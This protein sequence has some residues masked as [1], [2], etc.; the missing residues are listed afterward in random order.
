MMHEILHGLGATHQDWNSLEAQGYK[1]DPEDRGLMTFEHGE[2]LYLGLE[3]K[4]RALLGWPHVGVIRPHLPPTPTFTERLR[5]LGKAVVDEENSP[6]DQPSPPPADPT[7][8]NSCRRFKFLYDLFGE[9]AREFLPRKRRDRRRN[10]KAARSP[11]DHIP[12]FAAEYSSKKTFK[13][14]ASRLE[15]ASV[16]LTSIG[17]SSS[18]R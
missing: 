10:L 17:I 16:H 5:H 9:D 12:R 2:L 8:P 1:F 4:N 18:P 7:P 3:E 6:T 14:L 11:A 15:G 13:C